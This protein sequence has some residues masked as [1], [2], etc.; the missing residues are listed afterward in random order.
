MRPLRVR[1]KGLR[2]FRAERE[3]DFSDLGLVA[4][5]GDTG[6]G[7][8]SI[9]EAITYALYNATTWDQ[10]GVKQLISDGANTMSVQL[11][12]AVDGQVYRITRSTSRGA[13]PPAGHALECLTDETFARIDSED[14]IKAEVA[15]LVGLDWGG[16]TSAVI[17][18][19][20]RFQTLLQASPADKTEILKGIFRL[21]ELADAR[22]HAH[23]LATRYRGTLEELQ[24]TRMQL[25]P[26]PPAAAKQAARLKREAAKE[27]KRLRDQKADVAKREKEA[28][29]QD[30]AGEKLESAADKLAEENVRPSRDLNALVPVL[31]ELDAK[32]ADLKRAQ[33][34][35]ES[36]EARLKNAL[37]RAEAAGEGESQLE[38]ARAVLEQLIV[39]RPKLDEEQR[40][41]VDA[42]ETLARDETTLAT[43]ERSLNKL[44]A[45]ADGEAKALTAAEGAARKARDDLQEAKDR[46][47]EFRHKAR[48]ERQA[49]DALA[50]LVRQLDGAKKRAEAAEKAKT[51]AEKRLASATTT[52]EGLRR[53]HA[54]AH[55][56][57]GLKAGDPCPICR[58]SIPAGFKPP[59]ARAERAA[60]KAHEE[61]EAEAQKARDDRATAVA[62]CAQLEQALEEAHSKTKEAT[63]EAGTALKRA[64]ALLGQIDPETT[65]AELV[66]DLRRIAEEGDE[67]V[68]KQREVATQARNTAVAAEAA[69]KPRRKALEE[70]RKALERTARNL[71][72]RVA[73]LERDRLTL[74]APYQPAPS[75]S[76]G[77][78]Q[79]VLDRLDARLVELRR[80]RRD[81]EAV[82]QRLSQC[83]RDWEELAKRRQREFEDP[84]RRAEN[85]VL[86]LRKRVE[87]LAAAAGVQAP[88]P[89]KDDAPFADLI[90]SVAVLEQT[91]D[92]LV[93]AFRSK[94]QEARAR[95]IT[96]RKAI[97]EALKQAGARDLAEL[98]DLLIT[99][100]A[101]AKRAKDDEADAR[102]QTPI[103]ADLDRRIMPLRGAIEVLET[104]AS[105]LTDGRF[106][107]YIVS[108]RQRALLGLA[109]EILGSMTGAR[110]GFAEDFRIIDRI[111]GR[112]R[113]AKTLSGGETFLASLALA[114]GLV[115]LAARGGGRLE[116]L[117]LDEGFGSLDA[118]ALEEALGELER[119]AQ[120]GRL[121]AVISHVRAVA[122]RIE[123]VLWVTHRPE[124]SEV[125]PISGTEREEFVAEEVEE[126]L[127]A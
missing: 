3:I 118:D 123:Q 111:S 69:L 59:Q 105:L 122:E 70:Q 52:L 44:N 12:F 109:S 38:R 104:L 32:A 113:N 43:D 98:E 49:N 82:Q 41:L 62:T 83:R 64:Q 74:P 87:E 75:A 19:Q 101:E 1:V 110:Y 27:E 97:K 39:G 58:Q 68:K 48:D 5:V 79:K 60:Q 22:E 9:L 85:K 126:G 84:R 35:A 96:A 66:R 23:A 116:A 36:D 24:A 45:D 13:Y 90:S 29:G 76:Q 54:A 89:P 63:R 100:S 73:S 55:A 61:A 26:D 94:A 127:L 20:G 31:Q 4:I 125:T 10:R 80:L 56:A 93:A 21:R 37:E 71:D 117:F 77:Q 18:P 14:A 15:R 119:R 6:A 121:V 50:R 99:A 95:A 67:T 57:Q 34:E 51:S 86:L 92:E 16:F 8:S 7:K 2:S 81:Q 91:A 124:G 11:D 78:R 102:R 46:L 28:T 115:E 33:G 114:L 108:R 53:E 25:L 42:K 30:D 106:I 103:A 17:L 65:D 112:P 40:D 120:A 88:A 107:G 72:E 47:V